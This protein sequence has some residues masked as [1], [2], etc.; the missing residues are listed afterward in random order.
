MRQ[1]GAADDKHAFD[2]DPQHRLQ[3]LERHLERR[4][5]LHAKRCGIDEEPNVARAIGAILPVVSFLGPAVA[6]ILTGS[7]VVEKIFNI[8]GLGAHFIEAAT[9]RDYTLAMGLVL[10]Y[11]TLLCTMNLLVDIS[12]ALIDPRVKLE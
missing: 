7:L 2:I 11:T 8:P 12:Y 10:L 4:R 6:G 3:G 9:Q 1:H 5:S